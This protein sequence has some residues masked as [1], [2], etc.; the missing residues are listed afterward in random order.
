MLKEWKLNAAA[1][2]AAALAREL[3][4][5]KSLANIL[6]NRGI[7]TKAEAEVFLQPEKQPF[8]DPFLMKDMDK[9]AVRIA[10]AIDNEEKIMVYGDYDVDGMTAAT[11]MVHNLR[12]L[13]ADVDFYIPHREKEGYGFNL[14]ALQSIAEN[15][16]QLLVSVDCG[17]ASV[18]DVAA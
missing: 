16:V 10:D 13:G 14:P 9:A 3:G 7:C 6:W 2:E 11:L 15:G 12:A 17:I 4:V 5:T 1:P 18:D 8:Y